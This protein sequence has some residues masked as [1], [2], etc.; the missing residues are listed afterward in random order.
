VTLNYV[1]ILIKLKK[2]I[3]LSESLVVLPIEL[4]KAPHRNKTN[5][6]HLKTNKL[7]GLLARP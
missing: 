2:T 7:G 4:V 3:S 6:D 1:I 5:S